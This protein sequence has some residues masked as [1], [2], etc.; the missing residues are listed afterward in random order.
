MTKPQGIGTYLA[1]GWAANAVLTYL[2]LVGVALFSADPGDWAGLL[3]G[4]PIY[5]WIIGTFGA[6]VGLFIWFVEFVRGR[7]INILF[8]GAAAILLPVLLTI[9]IAALSGFLHDVI[10]LL[11][12]TTPL[13]IL[14]LPPALLSGSR[15]NPLKIIVMDLAESLPKYG[16]AR[17]LF[18]T[19]VPLLRFASLLGMLEAL[20]FLA[21]Q[22]PDFSAW[23]LIER[24]FAGALM[25]VVYFAITLTAALCLP[26]RLIALAIGIIAN[27]PVAGFVLMVSLR[28]NSEYGPLAVAGWVFVLLWAV[29]IVSQLLHP[30]TRRILPLTMVEIRIR[31]ALNCW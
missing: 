6:A 24:E 29:F 14:A 19:A 9:T 1:Q 22:R 15:L 10:V 12:I 3:I 8:R 13:V 16:W 11:W 30:E 17:A 21:C 7:K 28:A 4:M 27:V 31:H 25:A 5:V 18:I 23:N 20:L 2:L 26:H